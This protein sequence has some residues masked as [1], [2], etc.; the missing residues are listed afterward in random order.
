MKK[1]ADWMTKAKKRKVKKKR[2]RDCGCDDAY[3]AL[4][5]GTVIVVQ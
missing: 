3:A 2:Q 5:Q 4:F 1:K